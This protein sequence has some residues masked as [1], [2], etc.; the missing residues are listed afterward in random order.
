MPQP[1]TTSPVCARTSTLVRAGGTRSTQRASCPA[2]RARPRVDR[3]SATTTTMR[4]KMGRRH[5]APHLAPPQSNNSHRRRRTITCRNPSLLDWSQKRRRRDRRRH[6]RLCHFPGRL[7]RPR[8][9]RRRVRHGKLQWLP[10]RQRARHH[11][12]WMAIAMLMRRLR[13]TRWC[14]IC[15]GRSISTAEVALALAV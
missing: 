9:K 7:A 15:L 2:S 5:G 4:T 11:P 12:R 14:C 10:R 6:R 13:K 3:K 1:S 8:P